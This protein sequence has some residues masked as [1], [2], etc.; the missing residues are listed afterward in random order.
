MT[1][2]FLIHRELFNSIKFDESII[3]YGYEDT[4]FAQK[5]RNHYVKI[6]HIDNP[7]IHI[8]LEPAQDFLDKTKNGMNNLARMILAEKI[9]TDIK[10]YRYFLLAK[11]YKLKT[12]VLGLYRLFEKRIVRN[13]TSKKPALVLFDFF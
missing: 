7:L 4:L 6:E 2:N 9:D 1:N 11:N 3:G 5:L 12:L 8:G 13:L 10:I